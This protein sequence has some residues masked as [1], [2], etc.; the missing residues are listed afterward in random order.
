[1]KVV[2]FI[3]IYNFMFE[4]YHLKSSGGSTYYQDIKFGF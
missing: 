3:E 4:L 1:M 2:V